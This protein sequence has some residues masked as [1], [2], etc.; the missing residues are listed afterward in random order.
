MVKGNAPLTEKLMTEHL[1][2]VRQ[3]QFG[4]TP[5]P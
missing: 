3:H 2:H 1:E 5:S 4:N